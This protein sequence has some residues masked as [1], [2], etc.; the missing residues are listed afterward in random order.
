MPIAPSQSV[1]SQTSLPPL[2][3]GPIC[4]LRSYQPS[5][6]CDS[7]FLVTL[8]RAD[9]SRNPENLPIWGQPKQARLWEMQVAPHAMRRF[10]RFSIKSVDLVLAIG[11][12][13]LNRVFSM[14]Q[15]FTRAKKQLLIQ[16]IILFHVYILYAHASETLPDCPV[17]ITSNPLSKSSA[18]KVWVKTGAIL[19][20]KP[21]SSRLAILSHVSHI[22]R[23][24]MPC[25][26]PKIEKDQ[27]VTCT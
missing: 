20:C 1:F 19:S 24:K 7:H 23:P 16:Y 11:R 4:R 3:L 10:S 8:R 13:R 6:S 14:T 18:G 9:A 26:Q 21:D 12:P 5:T 15:D 2:L 22:S 27:L 25:K 17:R